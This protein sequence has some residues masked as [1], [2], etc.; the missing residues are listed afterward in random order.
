MNDSDGGVHGY[1]E[2]EM[3][4]IDSTILRL[5]QMTIIEGRRCEDIQRK[6]E[7]CYRTITRKE[8]V[9]DVTTGSGE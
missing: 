5:A 7:Q 6:L 2:G 8:D 9:P 4:S 3:E 1:V